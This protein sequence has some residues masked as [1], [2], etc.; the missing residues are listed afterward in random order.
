M[1][2]SAIVA[3]LVAVAIASW[4]MLGWLI[5][6]LSS[7]G[8]VDLPNHRTLHDRPVPR[9]GGMIIIGLMLISFV[10]IG[11]ISGRVAMFA[12][13]AMLMTGWAGLSWYDDRHNL[14]PGIRVIVQIVLA[15]V[16]VAA[17]GYIDVVEIS[18]ALSLQLGISGA[19]ITLLGLLWFANLYNFMDGMDGLAASQ[20]IIA[21]LTIGFWLW[22]FGDQGLALI[23]FV[24]AA[25]SYGFLLHNWRPAKIFL[26]DVGSITLGAFFATMIIIASHRYGLPVISFVLLF[27]VFVLD[28]S[29][30][31]CA[32]IARGE[33]FWLPHRTHYYQ[34]LANRGVAHDRIVLLMIAVMLICSLFA[35]IS[36]LY[37]DI[38]WL[39]VVLEL[40]LL[41]GAAWLTLRSKN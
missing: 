3:L 36:L 18:S 39:C 28:A 6:I 35:T 33:K 37:R 40:L 23:C 8:I 9:G 5:N 11:L 12:S 16:T 31:L 25:A 4:L 29:V 32:R 10:L 30:T 21:A 2:L 1:S 17:Y 15:A 27:G 20:T 7:R 26:G 13:Y 14:G 34:R 38:I 24:T 41:C 19:A 22:Q